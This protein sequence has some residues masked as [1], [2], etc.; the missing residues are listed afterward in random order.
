MSDYPVAVITGAGS[1]IG[2]AAAI[3]LGV[4]GWRCALVGRRHDKLEETATHVR[5]L[6]PIAKTLCIAADIAAPPAAQRIVDQT[7][8][9]W[10][11]RIDALI[12]N[13]AAMSAVRIDQASDVMMRDMFEVNVM[14]ATRL[15]Q[16]AWPHMLRRR[17]GRII[18][19]SSISS[20]DP[21]PGLGLYGMTKS[22][23]EGLTRAVNNEGEGTGILAFSLVLGAVETEMLRQVVSE[24][25]LP[26]NQVRSPEE[27]ARI[28][29]ACARG[30][31]DAEATKPLIIA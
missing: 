10:G 3:E 11:G 13:A 30:E 23:L 24:A 15:V 4:A 25:V 12:N 14:A 20:V 21:Y 2:R 8:E 31:R 18:N 9:Q 19:V 22:A 26:R 5:K 7:V 1:G 27:I 6:M 28:I 29:V 16:C 17:F